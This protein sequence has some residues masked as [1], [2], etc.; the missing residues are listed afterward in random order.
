MLGDLFKGRFSLRTQRPQR[1]MLFLLFVS[2]L[3]LAL[4]FLLK[5]LM[6]GVAADGHIIV[7]GV[8]FLVTSALLL[9]ANG[10]PPGRIKAGHMSYRA[11]AAIG[12]AQAVAPLPG[13]SR[14]GSTLSTGLILGL[15][16]K[17][18]LDFSFIMGIPAVIGAL[19]LDA[20]EILGGGLELPL[21]VVL[22]GLV[23]SLVFGLLAIGMVRWLVASQKLQWF[24]FY[25][26]L[27]GVLALGIGIYD[28][29]AGHP[30]QAAVIALFA[31]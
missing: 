4:T 31:K 2:L 7:E 5:D 9:L 10:C 11:A 6:Q 16:R 12:L 25:T 21:G 20:K 28:A 30:V 13:I 19:L 24:G 15:D 23:T 3:P 26:L 29:A 18:A 17:F 8:C 1:R 22:A 27:L 14:S